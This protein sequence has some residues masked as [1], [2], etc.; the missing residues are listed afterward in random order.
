MKNWYMLKGMGKEPNYWGE[1][2]RRVFVLRTG[3]E[4]NQCDYTER[5]IICTVVA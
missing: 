5:T 1:G 2:E 3:G 4:G